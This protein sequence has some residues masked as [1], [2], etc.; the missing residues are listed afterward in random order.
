MAVFTV[1]GVHEQPQ[2]L[3]KTQFCLLLFGVLLFFSVFTSCGLAL[4]LLFP[5][6]LSGPASHFLPHLRLVS[7]PLFVFQA[8]LHLLF[9]WNSALCQRAD[10]TDLGGK[11]P[12]PL[13]GDLRGGVDLLLA[14]GGLRRLVQ[15]L[16]DTGQRRL[17]AHQQSG[18]QLLPQQEIMFCL[19]HLR[20]KVRKTLL[21]PTAERDVQH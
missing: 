13:S 11:F 5:V 15:L 19:F 9:I 3:Q 8:W 14:I 18:L 17:L 16:S 12:L 20:Q 2:T 1:E 21:P 7:R 10:G 6:V 4:A